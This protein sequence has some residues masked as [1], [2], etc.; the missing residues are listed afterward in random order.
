MQLLELYVRY[1][2]PRKYNLSELLRE[3]SIPQDV[4]FISWHQVK[5]RLDLTC[6]HKGSLCWSILISLKLTDS[7]NDF[8]SQVMDFV[9]HSKG[10]M[11]AHSLNLPFIAN[12]YLKRSRDE[13]DRRTAHTA[14]DMLTCLPYFT[15]FSKL[16]Q[17]FCLLSLERAPL[18]MQLSE[19]LN[20][21]QSVEFLEKIYLIW[22][23]CFRF[24]HVVGLCCSS[25]RDSCQVQTI[26]SILHE[27]LCEAHLTNF[28]LE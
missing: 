11:Q 26:L 9:L 5:S 6:D 7:K 27:T 25:V 14:W 17:I 18:E 28:K 22:H 10:F 24:L 13:T 21:L 20:L 15:L 12:T 16:D 2:E 4:S 8:L 23:I 1:R 3:Q 19:Q